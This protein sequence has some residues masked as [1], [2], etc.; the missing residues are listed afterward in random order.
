M[1][2]SS[3]KSGTSPQPTNQS[4]LASACTLP[5][6][7]AEI[8]GGWVSWL[9]SVAVL[10]CGSRLTTIPRDWLCTVGEAPLSKML[11]VPFGE[12]PRVVLPGGGSRG[13]S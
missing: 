12:L 1:G 13:P 9:T 5:W 6:L 10:L 7:L 3:E 8:G 4:P 11:N 2:L